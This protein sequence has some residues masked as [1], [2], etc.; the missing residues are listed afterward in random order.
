M[1]V[2]DFTEDKGIDPVLLVR[3]RPTMPG[4]SSLRSAPAAS[5]ATCSSFFPSSQSIARLRY[6]EAN[7][8][9]SVL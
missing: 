5:A 1:E 8:D 6:V 9:T 2:R 7:L 4:A 3:H